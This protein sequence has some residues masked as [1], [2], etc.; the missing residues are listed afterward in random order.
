MLHAD[1]RIGR[2]PFPQLTLIAPV[3]LRPH[4]DGEIRPRS[5]G[6]QPLHDR[7]SLRWCPRLPC[8]P[9]AIRAV[10]FSAASEPP[11]IH[12]GMRLIG[13]SSIVSVGN[14]R[15][16]NAYFALNVTGSCVHTARIIAMPSSIRR[17]RLAER[18]AKRGEFQVPASQHPRRG[19]SDPQ[20]G[21]ATSIIPSASGSGCRI[22]RTSIVVPRRT[23]SV[24][25][26]TQLSVTTGS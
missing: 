2:D 19:S 11:P 1:C 21:C 12:S 4:R 15:F 25:A 22:G 10:R 6:P 13:C 5:F 3:P 26:A 16:R 20:T 9:S 7:C 8:Q 18:N 23:R 14:L 24:T 17:P